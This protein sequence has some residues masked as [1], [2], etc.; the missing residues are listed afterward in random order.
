MIIEYE[1][2]G[3]IVH[4]INDPVP[5]HM[6]EFLSA[7]GKPFLEVS[8]GGSEISIDEHF[9]LNGQVSDRP[10]C[11]VSVRVA[12]RTIFFDGQI[13]NCEILISVDGNEMDVSG[14]REIEFDEAGTVHILIVPE[15][16][17]RRAK[18]EIEIK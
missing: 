18:H 13:S 5:P 7:S 1:E 8:P 11:P 14:S 2:G 17:C 12:G 4:I 10:N 16:P 9:V 3:R 15:W 6:A